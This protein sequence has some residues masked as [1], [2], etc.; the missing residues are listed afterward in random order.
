MH[1]FIS[2]SAPSFLL[3]Y[4]SHSILLFI[5]THLLNFINLIVSIHVP[6]TRFYL[7]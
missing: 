7:I 2:L 6:Q 5:C 3:I 4:V 1:I